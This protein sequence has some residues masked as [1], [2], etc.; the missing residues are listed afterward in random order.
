MEGD[1]VMTAS[2]MTTD[3]SRYTRTPFLIV[4]REQSRRKDVYGSIDDTVVLQA[5]VMRGFSASA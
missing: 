1:D 2:A 3:S 4:Q 5:Q